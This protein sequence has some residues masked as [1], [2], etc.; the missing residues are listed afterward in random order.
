[1]HPGFFYIVL[2][3]EKM[4]PRATSDKNEFSL[5]AYDDISEFY[6]NSIKIFL[7]KGAFVIFFV[8]IYHW[9]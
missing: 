9:L 5:Q 3:G 8:S 1:M 2:L 7:W 6:C 4:G